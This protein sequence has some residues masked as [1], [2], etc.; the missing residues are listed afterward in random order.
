MQEKQLKYPQQLITSLINQADPKLLDFYE[1]EKIKY[2]P[3]KSTIQNIVNDT[4]RSFL[5]NETSK[6]ELKNIQTAQKRM[7]WQKKKRWA[8]TVETDIETKKNPFY[9]IHLQYSSLSA[10]QFKLLYGRDSVDEVIDELRDK[11]E[12]WQNDSDQL[13]IEYPLIT[14]LSPRQILGAYK[15]DLIINLI[16]VI[17]NFLGGDINSF[18]QKKPEILIDAPFF[19]P[20][21][22]SIPLKKY[23][24]NMAATLFQSEDLEFEILRARP[25]GDDD[26]EKDMDVLDFVDNQILSALFT[27]IN[28]DFYVSREVFAYIRD[29]ALVLNEKPNARYYQVVKSRLNKMA[30]VSFRYRYKTKKSP[31]DQALTFAFFDKVI[32]NSYD[33]GREYCNV[34]FSTTLYDAIIQKKMISV[35]SS[36]YNTLDTELS[37]LLYHSLQRERILLFLS[38]GPNAE[39]LLYSTYDI[40]FFQRTVLLKNKKKAKNIA[41]V[42]ESL[43]EFQRKNIAIARYTV[44]DNQFHIYFHSL[45]ADEKID[46]LEDYSSVLTVDDME[47]KQLA[48]SGD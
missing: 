23:F 38:S 25:D 9:N 15:I 34:T 21:K 27:N 17:I 18:L 48:T 29:I 33:D 5:K 6:P 20:Q 37:K 32:I 47:L 2:F 12:I 7:R 42:K 26:D 11:V 3:K 13:L 19:S 46:L 31:A 41:I 35:T 22:Y 40:S 8:K 43:D 24:D 1:S 4:L 39:N 14:S 10:S 16:D 44:E 36:S 30:T 45:T 28:A